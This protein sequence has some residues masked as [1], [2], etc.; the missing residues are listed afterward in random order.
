MDNRDD[1]REFLT[2]RRE[3]LTPADAGLPDFG[4]RRRVKG[5]REEVPSSPG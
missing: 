1:L 4:G 5:A 2:S 3:R